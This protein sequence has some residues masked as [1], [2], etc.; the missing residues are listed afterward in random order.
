L[1]IGSDVRVT[2]L[3]VERGQVRVGIEAPGQVTILRAELL[4]VEDEAGDPAGR[5]GDARA[6]AARD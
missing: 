6:A 3:R 4:D 5:P 2:I 1:L